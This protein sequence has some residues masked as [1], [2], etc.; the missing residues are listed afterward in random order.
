MTLTAEDIIVG[1]E[2]KAPYLHGKRMLKKIGVAGL[3]LRRERITQREY[4]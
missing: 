1:I 3:L 2:V 4:I